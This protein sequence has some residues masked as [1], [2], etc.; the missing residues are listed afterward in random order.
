MEPNQPEGDAIWLSGQSRVS[1]DIEVSAKAFHDRATLGSCRHS[2][3]AKSSRQTQDFQKSSGMQMY[4]YVFLL[5]NN[6]TLLFE[7]KQKE[8]I[9][10]RFPVPVLR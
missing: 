9:D 8:C 3:D 6:V 7:F 2:N 4:V 5:G 10:V 1:I